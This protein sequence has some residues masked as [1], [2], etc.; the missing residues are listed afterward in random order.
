MAHAVQ[1]PE[2]MY[3]VRV[4]R[5]WRSFLGISVQLSVESVTES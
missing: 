5:L 1:R 2:E 3:Q 4:L